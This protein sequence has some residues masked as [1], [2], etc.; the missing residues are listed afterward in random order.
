[1][2][3]KRNNN[4]VIKSAFI[5]K[6]GQLYGRTSVLKVDGEWSEETKKHIIDI[7]KFLDDHVTEVIKLF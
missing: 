6:V 4:P 7:S 1:M 3:N 2:K 5:F